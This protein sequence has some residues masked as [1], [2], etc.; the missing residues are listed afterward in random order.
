MPLV[1]ADLRRSRI[2]AAAVTGLAS[3]LAFGWFPITVPEPEWTPAAVPNPGLDPSWI[4]GVNLAPLAGLRFGTVVIWTYGPWGRIDLPL[5]IDGWT[6]ALGLLFSLAAT[7]GLGCLIG[8]ALGGPDRPRWSP[9]LGIPLTGLLAFTP[10]PALGI[11]PS[12]RVAM[13]VTGLMLVLLTASTPLRRTTW[14]W[15]LV[16]AAA[17]GALLTVKF[18]EGLGSLL[19]VVLAGAFLRL[20]WWR[21]LTLPVAVIGSMTLTWLLA[22]QHATD[23]PSW[24]QGSVELARGYP[25]AMATQGVD[26]AGHPLG[27][28]L[29][30]G[31]MSAAALVAAW[32]WRP[33][34]GDR[35][36]LAGLTIT[37]LVACWIQ[38]RVGFTQE[39]GQ[40]TRSYA[41]LGVLLIVLL[42]IRA[43]LAVQ[44][45]LPVLAGALSLSVQSSTFVQVFDP[46]T[47]ARVAL[48]DVSAALWSPYREGILDRARRASQD[49]YQLPPAMLDIIG[50]RTVHVD[51][52]ETT[53][54]WSYGLTWKPAPVF[55]A[56]S[57]WTVNLDRANADALASPAGPELVLREPL[58]SI[59][60]RQPLWDQPATQLALLCG[61]RTVAQEQYWLLLERATDRCS[62]PAEMFTIEAKAGELVRLPPTEQ[63][64]VLLFSVDPHWSLAE[65]VQELAFKPFVL[66]MLTNDQG[67]Y[68]LV[69]GTAG[70]P[71][72]ARVGPLVNE[73]SP[74]F[75]GRFDV[76]TFRLNHDAA[77][78]FARVKVTAP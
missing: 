68:R 57:V 36:R 5:V 55:Q 75:G 25:S 61:Y 64:E 21:W 67:T 8:W 2:R 6:F 42:R 65:R 29:S 35:W 14:R 50:D 23:L 16:G 1:E 41:T 26:A 71:M 53:V 62:S 78:T 19:I 32:R 58:R 4:A 72:I 30:F 47:R 13:T 74:Q 9:Y 12:V 11:A 37:V 63:D 69:P 44:V 43:V 39:G 40:L 59:H 33:I 56:Y 31:L 10:T 51:S 66:P 20:G 48:D 46:A 54:A 77:V 27:L 76:G 17:S 15:S 22:G 3:A 73:W 38:L 24:V 49:R 70:G 34:L 60:D 28:Y 7:F 52:T 18:S 45:L